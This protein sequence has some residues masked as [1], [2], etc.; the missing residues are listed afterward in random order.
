MQWTKKEKTKEKKYKL[1]KTKKIWKL[2]KPW[3]ENALFTN[4]DLDSSK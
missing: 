1:L 2:N 3:R 4:E